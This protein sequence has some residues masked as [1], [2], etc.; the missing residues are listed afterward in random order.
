MVTVVQHPDKGNE[1]QAEKSDQAY[2][3]SRAPNAITQIK[4]SIK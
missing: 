4:L 2:V 3:T 1:I